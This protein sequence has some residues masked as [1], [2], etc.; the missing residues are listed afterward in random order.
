MLP[1][2][3]KKQKSSNCIQIG[4]A[5]MPTPDRR[6]Y[7]T[8]EN[9][10]RSVDVVEQKTL[11][12]VSWLI[13][14]SFFIKTNTPHRTKWSSFFCRSILNVHCKPGPFAISC[15]RTKGDQ[16]VITYS[17][18]NVRTHGS[19][20]VNR[21]KKR[22]ICSSCWDCSFFH[23]QVKPIEN[24]RRYLTFKAVKQKKPFLYVLK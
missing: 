14:Q 22:P 5:T 2:P 24:S 21:E 23:R 10:P 20:I 19:C 18:S 1:N 3:V 7:Y 15:A 17:F 6:Q 8:F 12:N 11:C 16:R 9:I 4:M 13:H